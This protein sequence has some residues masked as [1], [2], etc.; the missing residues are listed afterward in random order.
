MRAQ[1]LFFLGSVTLALVMPPALSAQ[2]P[3]APQTPT[4]PVTKKMAPATQT[5]NPNQLTDAEKKEGWILL[6]D[7]KT[8]AGWRGYKKT[9]GTA[10]ADATKSSLGR[11]AVQNGAICLPAGSGQDTHGE[12]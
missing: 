8:T 4:K 5:A 1:R 12:R 10:G 7:G 6:F 3:A 11:W 9:G 2:Q